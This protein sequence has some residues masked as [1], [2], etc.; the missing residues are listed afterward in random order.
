MTKHTA[1]SVKAITTLDKSVAILGK[2]KLEM[3]NLDTLMWSVAVEDDTNILEFTETGIICGTT[4][5]NIET[6]EKVSENAKAEEPVALTLKWA[7]T[8][9]EAF[10]G[11]DLVWRIDE[12]LYKGKLLTAITKSSLVVQN[13]THYMIYDVALERLTYIKEGK[14]IDFAQNA[15][16]FIYQTAEGVFLMNVK[17]LEVSEFSK[18]YYSA[19]QK[20]NTI[21]INDRSFSFP[22]NCD[23]KCHAT[24]GSGAVVSV[25]KCGSSISSVILDRHG[26]IK[27]MNNLERG[28][29]G[30]C[31]C[32]DDSASISYTK[33]TSGGASKAFVS[34]FGLANYSVRGFETEA[35]ITAAGKDNFAM[36]NGKLMPI[37]GEMFHGAVPWQP[38]GLLSASYQAKIVVEPIQGSWEA[39]RSVVDANGCLAVQNY[40]IHVLQ[41]ATDD[42]FVTMH[43][44][45][46][47]FATLLALGLL[48]NS[49]VSKRTSFWK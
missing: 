28:T 33:P 4:E 37:S 10:N 2:K 9:I 31:W 38:S 11:N 46:I 24:C 21:T 19:K 15:D 48:I 12:P 29:L 49:Y 5:Y 8:A 17:T 34:S 45:I 23:T 36:A 26:K 30:T 35:L 40:D 3:Y 20:N 6:G 27:Y 7:P 44:T 42:G 16:G 18:P 14:I 25:A 22:S 13:K 39:V 47:G 43:M 1:G 32:S 41:G